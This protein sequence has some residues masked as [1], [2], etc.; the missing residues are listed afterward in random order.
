MMSQQRSSNTMQD[1]FGAEVSVT[2]ADIGL[3]FVH[4]RGDGQA[5]HRALSSAGAA[6]AARISTTK[7]LAVVRYTGFQQLRSSSAIA[8]IGPV[9]LD[10]QRFELFR[11]VIGGDPETGTPDT[12]QT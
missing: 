9:A 6:I 10:E 5:M 8:L 7:V 3:Y 11:R 12:S 2:T 4:G 1:A